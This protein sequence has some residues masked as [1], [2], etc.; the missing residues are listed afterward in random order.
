MRIAIVI[1]IGLVALLVMRFLNKLRYQPIHN[2]WIREFFKL[3]PLFEFVIWT[4]FT[5]WMVA[6]LFA[7]QEYYPLLVIA[8]ILV[9]IL[10]LGW[11]IAKD[12]MAGIIIKA[13]NV[14]KPGQQIKAGSV[15]GT[16]KR[17]G[18]LHL[19]LQTEQG[20]EARIPYA[21]IS[22]QI[23]IQE[24]Q[25]DASIHVIQFD[26]PASMN[27]ELWNKRIKRM[28]LTSPYVF[29]GSESTIY[30]KPIEH[31][32]HAEVHVSTLTAEHAMNLENQ[33]KRLPNGPDHPLFKVN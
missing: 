19:T 28:L 10:L 24:V 14:Y 7:S 3:F 32:Y 1:G 4:G 16:I 22:D 25:D 13:Q 21:K 26:L 18:N 23:I 31:G 9:L 8:L 27:G 29:A 11:F 5:F 30:I 12:Y 17:L 6:E 2:F 20:E 33:L 15:S